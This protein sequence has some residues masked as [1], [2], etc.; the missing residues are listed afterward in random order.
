M[1]YSIGV[2]G[3][4]Y[5]GL[6]SG[7]CF[8]ESGNNVLCVDIDEAKVEKLRNGIL[9]IYEPDLDHILERNIKKDRLHFT[10]DLTKAVH[11]CT[12]L[13]LCLPTPPDED[14]SADLAYVLNAAADIAHIIVRDGIDSP[15]ILVNKSTVPVGTADK[16]RAVVHG[17]IPKAGAVEIVSN[18][19]FLREG[20][21]VEDF[22]K[23]D[24]V[25]VGTTSK[26]AEAIM[27]DLYE[28]FV[29]SGNPIYVMDEKSAEITK[30]A[31]NCFLAMRIS[32]MNDLSNYCELVGADIENVRIGIGSDTRI[33]KRFL[34]AGIGYGGSCF[35]KDVKALIHST[36][37]AERPL[38][39]MRAVEEVNHE[40]IIR[41]THRII[42]RFGSVE[43]KHFA[44]WGLAFKPDTDDTRE[45]PAFR[46]IDCLLEAGATVTAYDPEATSNSERKYGS[47]ITFSASAMGALTGADALIIATEWQEFRKPDFA[48]IKQVLSQPIIF[49]GRNLYELQ[50]METAGVEYYSVGR[51]TIIPAG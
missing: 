4:G 47:A 46:I 36:D 41:F 30:Y 11:E 1:S 32:F 40:Q 50:T 17:I 13:F 35:P 29:R 23:P 3:T 42:D 33:G 39:I 6:V 12:I 14:G 43:G 26:S 49:D 28:P 31:A 22:M 38:K 21:A 19:E 10:T 16:V 5:V 34:F 20:F 51:R 24:R 44:L 15:R 45:S 9:P 27:R 48:K 18:P 37:A 7:T 2:I 25:V 8:A